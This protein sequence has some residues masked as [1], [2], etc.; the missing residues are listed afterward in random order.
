MQVCRSAIGGGSAPSNQPGRGVGEGA[1]SIAPKIASRGR[2]A[3]GGAGDLSWARGPPHP[4]PACSSSPRSAILARRGP[5]RPG[6]RPPP[7][8]AA[9]LPRAYRTRAPLAAGAPDLAM[10]RT[11]PL[12]DHHQLL[13]AHEPTLRVAQP[14]EIHAARE[15]DAAIVD[16]VPRQL[17]LA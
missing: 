7:P 4:A 1:G 5:G 13:R 16:A 9:R 6:E 10:K 14:H 3:A 15:L 8:P 2:R 12:P 17:M 11:N